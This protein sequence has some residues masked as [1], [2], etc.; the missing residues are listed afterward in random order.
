MELSLPQ[1]L[2]FAQG[3]LQVNPARIGQVLGI[4]GV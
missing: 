2:A 1:H 3:G 4:F